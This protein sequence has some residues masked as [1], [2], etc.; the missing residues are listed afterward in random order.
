MYEREIEQFKVDH[1]H[2]QTLS[3]ILHE[4]SWF[5]YTPSL[6]QS[7]DVD[8]RFGSRSTQDHLEIDSN[9]RHLEI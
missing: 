8:Y 7:H 9:S 6:E 1:S 4:D 5:Y 2:F 3:R